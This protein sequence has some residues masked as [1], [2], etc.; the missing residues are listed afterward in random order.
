MAFFVI[1]YALA[2]ALE[3][4]YLVNHTRK[5]RTKPIVL[6]FLAASFG[7]NAAAYYTKE[8]LPTPNDVLMAIFKPLQTW[9]MFG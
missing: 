8:G 9:L 4:R 7:Y 6:G 2:A 3:W 5:P 1:A